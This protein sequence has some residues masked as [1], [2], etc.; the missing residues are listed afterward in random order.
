[1]TTTVIAFTILEKEK[2]ETNKFFFILKK[3]LNVNWIL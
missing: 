2:S 1:M 3:T